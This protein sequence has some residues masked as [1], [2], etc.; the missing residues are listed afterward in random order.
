MTL[1]DRTGAASDPTGWKLTSVRWLEEKHLLGSARRGASA[2]QKLLAALTNLNFGKAEEEA[3][4]MSQGDVIAA[5]LTD[6]D[7]EGHRE[8]VDFLDNGG[9]EGRRAELRLASRAPG[10][11]IGG[12][13]TIDDFVHVSDDS[14]MPSVLGVAAPEREGLNANNPSCLQTLD[15]AVAFQ[16]NPEAG[17]W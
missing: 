16:L 9:Y 7:E 6:W 13:L 1:V 12:I 15:E 8:L 10:L 14:P 3:R 11:D 4:I 17:S 5:A 2:H